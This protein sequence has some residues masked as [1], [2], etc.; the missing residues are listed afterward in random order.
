MI[1]QYPD[2]L[3]DEL[4]LTHL[5]EYEI[6]LLDNTPVRLAPQTSPAK[7]AVFKGAY[8]KVIKRGSLQALIFQ[9]FYPHVPGSQV[10]GDLSCCRGFQSIE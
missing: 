5:T 7:D 4:G 6:Q 10:D 2:V 8:Q 1:S 9:L 3:N